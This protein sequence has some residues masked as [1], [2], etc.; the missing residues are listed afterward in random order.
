[1]LFWDGGLNNY[2]RRRQEHQLPRWRYKLRDA[3][4][5]AFLARDQYLIRIDNI[6]ETALRRF[7]VED[8]DRS[9]SRDDIF[10]Y[11]SD[12]LHGTL[13]DWLIFYCDKKLDRRSGLIDDANEWFAHPRDLVTTFGRIVYLSVEAEKIV[14]AL[15]DPLANSERDERRQR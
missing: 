13:L 5:R 7:R 10:G 8:G 6:P 3:R 4:Q 2:L 15:P 1:M 9:I 14:N 12:L 11:V